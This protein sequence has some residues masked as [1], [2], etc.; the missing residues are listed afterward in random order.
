MFLKFGIKLYLI[1]TYKGVFCVDKIEIS[2][3][4]YRQ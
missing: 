1:V 4:V 2:N 3:I